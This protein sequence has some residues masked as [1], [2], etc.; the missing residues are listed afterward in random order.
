MLEKK[1]EFSFL[2]NSN[3]YLEMIQKKSES[4]ESTVTNFEKPKKLIIKVDRYPNF[5]SLIK[6]VGI[7]EKWSDNSKKY[8]NK[9]KV[10]VLKK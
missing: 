2:T 6:L 1:M 10:N 5:L 7:S 8:N 3:L 9:Q 4:N